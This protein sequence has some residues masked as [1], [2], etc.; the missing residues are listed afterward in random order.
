MENFRK[1]LIEVSKDIEKRNEG[2]KVKY[3]AM[4]PE[5]IPNSITI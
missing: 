4:L 2:L 1:N 5:K 3:T